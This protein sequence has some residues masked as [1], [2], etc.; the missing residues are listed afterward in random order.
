MFLNLL[1]IGWCPYAKRVPSGTYR[2]QLSVSIPSKAYPLI[3]TF[4]MSVIL[5]CMLCSDEQ[6][7]KA[8][9]SIVVTLLGILMLC[10]DKQLAKTSDY[11]GKTI[12]LLL[13]D[14]GERYLSTGLFG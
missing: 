14:T 10:S 13:P 1:K 2:T 6:P 12:A 11:K 5:I 8:P 7:S 4:S 3:F 9:S